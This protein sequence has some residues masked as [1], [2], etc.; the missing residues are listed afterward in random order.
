MFFLVLLL[1]L[2][3]FGFVVRTFNMKSVILAEFKV[4]NTTLLHGYYVV[5]QNSRLIYFV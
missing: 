4:Y 5:Q 2:F 3:D 1:L